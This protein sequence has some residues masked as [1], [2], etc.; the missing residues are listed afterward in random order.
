MDETDV[1][2]NFEDVE[3]KELYVHMACSRMRKVHSE[4]G[5]EIFGCGLA[6]FIIAV[7][8]ALDQEDKGLLRK[9]FKNLLM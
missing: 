9:L 6:K 8:T 2:F 7:F 4:D 1:D 5:W 3:W